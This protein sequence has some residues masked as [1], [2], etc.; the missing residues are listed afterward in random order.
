MK[1]TSDSLQ[2]FTEIIISSGRVGLQEV[3][4]IDIIFKVFTSIDICW[5]LGKYTVTI[6]Q[7]S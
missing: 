5:E 3:M 1:A 7:I 2:E 4:H 6:V